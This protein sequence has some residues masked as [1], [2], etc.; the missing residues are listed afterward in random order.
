MS[1]AS[2]YS[3]DVLV[4]TAATLFYVA[5]TD[6]QEFKI[7]NELVLV[8]A[9]LF[10]IYSLLSGRWVGIY[11]N[12]ALAGVTF[13]AMLYYYQQGLMGG[14][15]VK[16]LAVAF[17]WVGVWGAV[18]FVVL[19]TASILVHLGVAKL[20]WAQYKESAVGK[21][22]P[23]GPSVAAALTATLVSGYLVSYL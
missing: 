15:D 2:V 19:L 8:L 14:G 16:L 7:R 11:W 6:L 22:I 12:I 4:L 17:L 10:L 18:P 9:G 23:L 3:Y 1:F 5:F 20:G 13:A 21:R